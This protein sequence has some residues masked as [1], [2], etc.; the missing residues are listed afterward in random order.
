MAGKCT[1]EP[2]YCH[3][4]VPMTRRDIAN[5][6]GLSMETVS[7]ALTRLN[8]RGLVYTMGNNLDVTNSR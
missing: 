2:E 3:V 5:Y 1:G 4:H 6:L 8:D 7:R